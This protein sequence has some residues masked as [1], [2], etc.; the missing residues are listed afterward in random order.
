M[1][2]ITHII[3]DSVLEKSDLLDTLDDVEQIFSATDDI[4]SL[5]WCMDTTI[6][7]T[8]AE[9]AIGQT[10]TLGLELN[11][12]IGEPICDKMPVFCA[13]YCEKTL[14]SIGDAILKGIKAIIN[15]IRKIT[16]K[17]SRLLVKFMYNI[18]Y[19]FNLD[20][21]IDESKVK[22][23]AYES[24]I[25]K[26]GLK[27]D[28]IPLG[29]LPLNKKNLEKGYK[30]L[31]DKIYTT[32]IPGTEVSTVPSSK[33]K[34]NGIMGANNDYSEKF[35][36]FPSS[37]LKKLLDTKNTIESKDKKV[38]ILAKIDN[39]I[40]TLFVSDFKKVFYAKAYLNFYVYN[41]AL[42][43]S[44]P[45]M[46]SGDRIPL[47]SYF[48]WLID[49]TTDLTTLSKNIKDNM[50]IDDVIG[51][52][53]TSKDILNN[54]ITDLRLDYDKAPPV[55]KNFIIK[56]FS[57]SSSIDD[58]RFAFSNGLNYFRDPLFT[59]DTIQKALT[60]AVAK[61]NKTTARLDKEI[62][63]GKLHDD[64]EREALH[65]LTG[66]AAYISIINNIFMPHVHTV[67]KDL[68][69]IRDS[70]IRINIL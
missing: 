52:Y 35:P 27:I 49:L 29:Y 19:M 64:K 53:A 58:V 17:L 42:K 8:S 38:F 63:S 65:A 10:N 24:L 55:N 32:A 51:W 57:P 4:L 69:I 14:E 16:R 61:I 1:R 31:T 68:K 28:N 13:S 59:D 66:M 36:I 40:S 21:L 67:G 30:K 60:S 44:V 25:D 54:Y 6:V 18:A 46:F 56:V 20:S 50:G 45:M 33:S 62:A 15:F 34:Y 37:Y 22:H 12:I 11:K 7:L 39:V 3:D 70:Y 23:E 9:E 26:S 2:N 43:I 48:T 41:D 47:A 5:Q